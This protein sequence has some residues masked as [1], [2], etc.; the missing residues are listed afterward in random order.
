MAG[1]LL[2]LL[3]PSRLVASQDMLCDAR[4]QATRSGDGQGQP[5]AHSLTSQSGAYCNLGRE[6]CV[7]PYGVNTCR[8]VCRLR[9]QLDI[10]YLA[11]AALAVLP[12]TYC[13]I[14]RIVWPL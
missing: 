11:Y 9:W 13:S 7:K 6:G 5:S 4:F 8:E 3:S 2:A 12:F 1:S 14:L 10:R